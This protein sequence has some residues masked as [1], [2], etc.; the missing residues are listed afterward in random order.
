MGPSA[1]ITFPYRGMACDA[2][3]NTNSTKIA[4]NINLFSSNRL[5]EKLLANNFPKPI[6]GSALRL[7]GGSVALPIHFPKKGL[8]FCDLIR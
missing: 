2:Q 5:I 4:A 3:A 1:I 7:S 6:A 8:S